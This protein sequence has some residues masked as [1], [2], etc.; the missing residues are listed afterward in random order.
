MDFADNQH[1]FVLGGPL[2]GK[3]V[4]LETKDGGKT[5]QPYKNQPMALPG[6]A[7]FAASGPCLRVDKDELNIV[8][9][10]TNSKLIRVLIDNSNYIFYSRISIKHSKATQGVFSIAKGS[11]LVIVGGD[12]K[13]NYQTD[14]VAA[15]W[16][17]NDPYAGSTIRLPD[18]PP[19]GYQPCVE[20]IDGLTF[21]STRTPG[22]NITT[23]GGKNQT[24]IDS[25]S[26]IV[27]RK[28]KHGKLVLL[29]GS[30]SKIAVFK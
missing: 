25:T 20:Y 17:Y 29:V 15:Y 11:C 27:C 5:W 3:F 13:N 18:V 7:A 19:V 8:T 1:G 9:D 4:L 21:L 30:N 24:K 16:C 10:G 2:N 28:A 23:D 22:S 6:E 26:Y 14:S 12:Y